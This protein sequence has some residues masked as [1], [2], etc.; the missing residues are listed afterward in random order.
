[1]SG[2][3]APSPSAP[4]EVGRLLAAVRAGDRAAEARLLELVYADLKRIAHRHLRGR[5][6]GE[7]LQT[8][9]L[10]H[11]AYVRLARPAL[12]D[13]ND[14]IHFLAVSSRAMRQILIDRARARATV[15]RGSGLAPLDLESHD[16]AAPERGEDLLAL[17]GALS[18]LEQLEP[19]LGRVVEM[20]FFGGMTAE[21]TGEVLGVSDRTVK[22]DWRKARAFLEA[23]LAAGGALSAPATRAAP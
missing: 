18:E 7:T 12:S 9:A 21:E 14:R 6:R 1:V 22:S 16:P 15:K 2:G 3:E 20:R 8:T 23:R 11:E 19:R 17:D 4:D 5:G 13:F 10:V